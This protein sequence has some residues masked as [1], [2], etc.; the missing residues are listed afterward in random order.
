MFNKRNKMRFI[1]VSASITA[2]LAIVGG[3]MLWNLAYKNKDKLNI[4]ND[5]SEAKRSDQKLKNDELQIK[6][7]GDEKRD[8]KLKDFASKYQENANMVYDKNKINSS[9]EIRSNGFYV[10]NDTLYSQG[11]VS[12]DDKYRIEDRIKA[13]AEEMKKVYSETISIKDS[14]SLEAYLDKGDNKSRFNYLYG[15]SDENALNGFIAKLSFLKND[16]ISYCRM[17]NVKK[18]D[19]NNISFS[20]NIITKENKSQSFKVSINF[21]DERA[22]LNIKIS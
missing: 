7:V 13:A 5:V 10:D 19:D 21:E 1:V 20:I 22:T 8:E 12:I 18:V 16:T 2:V 9:S 6:V 4:K 3:F 17:D 14:S 15:I 11:I